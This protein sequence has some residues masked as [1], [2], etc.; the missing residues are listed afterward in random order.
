MYSPADFFDEGRKFVHR[1]L[2]QE[3]LANMPKVKKRMAE[4][5]LPP[6]GRN[7]YDRVDIGLIEKAIK[8]TRAYATATSRDASVR[9]TH[10]YERAKAGG[11]FS[12][13]V[14]R[15][16]MAIRN[17]T[18][19]F[20]E[21]LD[22]WAGKALPTNP[23]SLLAWPYNQ[24]MFYY[25][26]NIGGNGGFHVRDNLLA[27]QRG[28]NTMRRDV[29]AETLV[30]ILTHP[31]YFGDLEAVVLY[32]MAIGANE[33]EATNIAVNFLSE[34]SSHA[35]FTAL[36]GTSFGDEILPL[37]DLS[38]ENVRRVVGVPALPELATK[39]L[40]TYGMMISLC[41]F[42]KTGSAYRVEVSIPEGTETEMLS[43]LHGIGLG[44]K[45]Y[46]PSFLNNQ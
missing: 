11:S 18:Y 19:K 17:V 43:A 25:G 34:M 37:I 29:P 26:W 42:C 7:A 33:S 41:E 13:N 24:L 22:L 31:A 21:K 20:V 28:S 40:Q 46:M 39:V 45:E 30:D 35:V 44:L 10:S 5:G 23:H 3:I 36:K 2:D 15:N 12:T 1:S 4:K 32:F 16:I 14:P 8:G 9:G 27:A 38:P 6:V